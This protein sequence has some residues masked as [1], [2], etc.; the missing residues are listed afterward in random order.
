MR[1][2]DIGGMFK[3]IAKNIQTPYKKS[4]QFLLISDANT[5]SPHIIPMNML[6]INIIGYFG[7]LCHIISQSHL[8]LG[9]FPLLK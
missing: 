5:Y 1:M 7:F 6:S 2:L 3:N 4:F 8:Y 9:T